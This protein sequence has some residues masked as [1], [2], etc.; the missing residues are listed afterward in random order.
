VNSSFI[1]HPSS[2]I[3]CPSFF[4]SHP[5][6]II[7]YSL[8]LV[9]GALV[10]PARA[11]TIDPP[12]EW[13]LLD[14][15]PKLRS[16]PGGEAD[17]PTLPF[18]AGERVRVDRRARGGEPEVD[19]VHVVRGERA[20]WLPEALLAPEPQKIEA[21]NLA[22]IGREPVDRTRGIPASYVP[23][24]L[25]EIAF[26][27]EK[28]R[29]YKL[30]REAA[31]ALARLVEAARAD[32]VS[33]QV[34][35]AFRSYELQRANYLAKLARSD[36]SQDTVAKPGHSE[37]QLGTTVDFTDGDEER[38]LTTSFG[39]T[40]AGIWLR[41]RAPEFG[42]ALSYTEAN[43]KRTGYA[44]EPWHYRY[45]G[46]AAARSIHEAALRGDR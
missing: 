44:P 40:E 14:D 6:S 41:R 31:E 22:R 38:M 25:V 4:T 8:F 43:R 2:F 3:L 30:R 26:G 35:S 18:D 21:G 45:Y 7:L 20:G 46:P 34:V 11:Q 15:R 10:A 19:W 42:F 33:L 1:L 24:D 27:Y 39:E 29:V 9:L 16:E 5:S 23:P 32:G 17:G 36:W 28:E 12:Q 37:H 13:I